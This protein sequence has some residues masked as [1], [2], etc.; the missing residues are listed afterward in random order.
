MAA[1]SSFSFIQLKKDGCHK[2]RDI[3]ACGVEAGQNSLTSA[4]DLSRMRRMF[5]AMREKMSE[6]LLEFP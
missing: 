3:F 5:S 2:N 4:R 1:Y 6:A